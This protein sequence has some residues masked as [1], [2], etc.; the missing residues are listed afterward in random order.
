MITIWHVTMWVKVDVN[1]LKDLKNFNM[2]NLMHKL[3][4]EVR[5]DHK[6]KLLYPFISLL[7]WF[8]GPQVVPIDTFGVRGT[9]FDFWGP[10]R[11]KG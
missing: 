8:R 3:L 1:N 9:F 4:S 2:Y 6:S 10:W 11:L 7:Q 5:E